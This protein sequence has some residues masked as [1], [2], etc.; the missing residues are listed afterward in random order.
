MSLP[1]I[2]DNQGELLCPRCGGTNLHHEMVSVYSRR[3][4]AEEVQATTVFA[5]G[6][7]MVEHQ[8]SKDGANPSSRRDGLV[9]SFSCEH[10]SILGR[11]EEMFELTVVQ[12]KGTTY[13][14]WRE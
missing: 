7:V 9:I 4:D 5:T 14:A 2:D 8:L 11:E 12:H 6:M 3:E 1:S 10:C 13:L